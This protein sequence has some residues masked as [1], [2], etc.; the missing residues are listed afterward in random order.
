MVLRHKVTKNI[1]MK[2]SDYMIYKLMKFIG[3]ND[4]L[5][6]NFYYKDYEMDLFRLQRNGYIIEYEIKI[7][8]SDYFND[9]KK[10]A[11]D[12]SAWKPGIKEIPRL[13]KHKLIEDGKIANKFFFVVP[14]NLIKIEEV[15]RY[16]GLIYFKSYGHETVKPAPFLHKNKF[17][18][19][20]WKDLA[21]KV[22]WRHAITRSKLF[23][24]KSIK[25]VLEDK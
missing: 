9:F 21:L 5:M 18:D 3:A 22:Y 24:G 14:D 1:T 7:S 20:E 19:Q 13:N 15:P 4:V 2:K 23:K 12:W 6:P 25:K 10:G 11:K 8:R 16:A 17:N